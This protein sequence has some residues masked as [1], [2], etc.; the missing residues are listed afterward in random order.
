MNSR[1]FGETLVSQDSIKTKYAEL[2]HGTDKPLITSG[3]WT[4]GWTSWKCRT[5][6]KNKQLVCKLY[7]YQSWNLYL[8]D[9]RDWC[10]MKYSFIQGQS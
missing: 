6:F 4:K 5:H 1:I 3:E 10:Q 2:S 8:H 9:F 7:K